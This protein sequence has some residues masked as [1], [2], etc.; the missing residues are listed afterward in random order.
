MTL[1]SRI[2]GPVQFVPHPPRPVFNNHHAKIILRYIKWYALL[3]LLTIGGQADAAASVEYN[4][5]R[6]PAVSIGPEAHRIIVGFRANG[7]NSVVQTFE[8]HGR[9]QSVK[10]VQATT[11]STDVKSLAGRVGIAIAKSRQITP[12]MHVMFLQTPLY[13]ASVQA[14]LDRL[15]A[16]P[17]VKFAD[18]DQRRFPLL[19]PDDPLFVATTGATG[20]WYMQTPSTVTGDLAA[21]DAVTAWGL[22]T[23]SAGVVIA[24]V[25]TGVRFDH[26]DLLRAG[27]GGRLLPGYDFVGQD[28]DPTT[29]TLLGTFLSANDGDGW[30]P[31]PSDPG[32]WISASDQEN[33]AFPSADCAI[34]DSSWHGTRVV[35][36]YGAIT[37]NDVGIAGMTWGSWILPVRALG[38]CGGYDSDIIAGIEWAAGISISTAA[39]PVTDNPYP[40]N[41]VNLSVGGSDACPTAYQDALNTVTGMGVL[42]VIAAG[43]ASGSVETPA[44][45]SALVSGVIAVAGIR[46]V[47]TK[48]GYSSFGP[49]V[50]VSAPA[51][52]CVNS[53]GACLRSIDT[54]TNLGTTTPGANS[55]TN[56]TNE[57]LGTSFATPIVSGIAGLM[58]SVNSNLTPAQLVARLESSATAFPANTGNLP[59]C[60]SVDPTTD[61]C[62]CPA[63]GECGTGMV[64]ASSA[65]NAALDPI[66][67][68]AFPTSFAA[69]TS[70]AF[71]ASG[72]TAACNRTLQSYAWTASGGLNILSGAGTTRVTASG[73]GVLTLVVTDSSGAT[74]TAT[75]T[76]GATT[77]S[78]GAPTTAG[79]AA[80]PTAVTVT[81]AAPTLSQTFSPTSV[82]VTV[83]ATLTITLT[84]SNAFDLTQVS[85]TDT[86][87]SALTIAASPAA[88]TSC[89]GAALSL[90]TAANV[91][92]FSGAII[93]AKGSCTITL[94]VSGTTAGSYAN[95][96]AAG[97]LTSGPA[98]ASA[99]SST[100]S[101]T[102]TAP[103]A[104]TIAE[105]FSPTSVAEN[106]TSTLSIV[107]SNSNAY[108]L[109]GAALSDALPANL[110]LATAPAASTSC[111][112]SLTTT[113]TA[114]KLAAATIPANGSCSLT[115]TLSSATAGTYTNTIAAGAL[116]TTQNAANAASA[117]ASLTVAAPSSGGGALR[118]VDL[119]VLAI[120]AIMRAGGSW[121]RKPSTRRA[122]LKTC[123]PVPARAR[124]FPS[125]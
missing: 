1:A 54:T 123:R 67:A 90:T 109:T 104:P 102:V 83:A 11:T 93:P 66:A 71:D 87:P 61:E 32:D 56:Q 49:E 105:S 35:G 43:N 99:A 116:S 19:V 118:W 59:V 96:I 45:C 94:Q 72:S 88:S 111:A 63:S 98:G 38:K 7:S 110:V 9:A 76:V 112:G 81:P 23:G 70:I 50:G 25:D 107:L 8:P 21:T 78:S 103:V 10:I 68:V 124:S 95:L 113:T 6:R 16:D 119:I 30:D 62:S 22:T 17:A 47:G 12:S 100:A 48:V 91:L 114:V 122:R 24:D 117:S 92:T 27:L 2:V 79:S 31:D 36:I 14:A 108:A 44:N 60:P 65:V 29:G 69:G 52:N 3:A 53:S 80:C 121:P 82:G 77:A 101:L 73:T 86:L 89:T 37:N 115:L 26:P 84:N 120:L 85:L 40:A 64:N 33:S 74:D 15:R 34:E 97:A 20:Q 106:A 5:V 57:N 58:R 41:I 18:V 28:Y 39:T 42:V 75:I 4:P 55:Y 51:G 125:A 46:N 13:G